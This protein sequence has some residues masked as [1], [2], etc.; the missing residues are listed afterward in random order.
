M[1]FC[2]LAKCCPFWKPVWGGQSH[3]DIFCV[4]TRARCCPFFAK[5]MFEMPF[6]SMTYCGLQHFQTLPCFWTNVGAN[7]IMTSRVKNR[8]TNHLLFPRTLFGVKCNAGNLIL[9]CKYRTKCCSISRSIFLAPAQLWECH[10]AKRVFGSISKKSGATCGNAAHLSLQ[11]FFTVRVA[12]NYDAGDVTK[13]KMP[14]VF[15][16]FLFFFGGDGPF[17]TPPQE[18]VFGVCKCGNS[19][20][21]SP[22]ICCYAA[23]CFKWWF[24]TRAIAGHYSQKNFSRKYHV[25]SFEIKQWK[26]LATGSLP[27]LIFKKFND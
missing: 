6:R 21:F 18:F 9:N 2:V 3:F 27:R 16:K 25:S 1:T 14:S 4:E 20:P 11:N 8:M 7:S 13:R 22:V 15:V 5:K 24:Q 10:E 17:P 19:W 26:M 23:R 12:Y